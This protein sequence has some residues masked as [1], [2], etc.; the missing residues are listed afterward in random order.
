MSSIHHKKTLLKKIKYV[1]KED[2]IIITTPQDE[3]MGIAISSNSVVFQGEYRKKT[4]REKDPTWRLHID[5]V[6]E[7]FKFLNKNPPKIDVENSEVDP[8]LIKALAGHEWTLII[9]TLNKIFKN[10]F[11]K[12]YILKDLEK[13]LNFWKHPE[14]IKKEITKYKLN[15][16]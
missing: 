3:Y 13:N 6:E 4:Y 16:I 11:S 10:K 15:K 14:K 8:Q 12:D 1:I 2:I 5:R 7:N 9:R